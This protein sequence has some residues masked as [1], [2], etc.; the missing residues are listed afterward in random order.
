MEMKPFDGATG[1]Q[2]RWLPDQRY[3]TN[4]SYH[5]TKFRV[6]SRLTVFGLFTRLNQMEYRMTEF[7]KLSIETSISDVNIEMS[8]PSRGI[9]GTMAVGLEETPRT[10]RGSLLEAQARQTKYADGK[11]MFE[12]RDMD[13]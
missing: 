5:G 1:I 4:W 11:E 7:T 6:V 9:Y 13:Y 2:S 10:L 8:I 3:Y 12:V